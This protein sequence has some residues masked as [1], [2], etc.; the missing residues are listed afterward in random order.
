MVEQDSTKPKD[1][2][3]PSSSSSSSSASSSRAAAASAKSRRG[4]GKRNAAGGEQEAR[5]GKLGELSVALDTLMDSGWGRY[6]T[7][8]DVLTYAGV[9][10]R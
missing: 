6:M 1:S 2:T 7:Y 9:C 10:C 3:K 4:G 8:A 5:A